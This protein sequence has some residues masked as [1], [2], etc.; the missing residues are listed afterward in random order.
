MLFGAIYYKQSFVNDR[1]Y[2]FY[3]LNLP[4]DES[5]QISTR[6]LKTKS[7]A[8]IFPSPHLDISFNAISAIMKDACSIVSSNS[9]CD[10][11]TA[12]PRVTEFTKT[13]IKDINLKRYRVIVTSYAISGRTFQGTYASRFLWDE[14]MDRC[15][16]YK[17]KMENG[18]LIC[19][20]YLIHME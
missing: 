16:E 7:N 4:G 2:S 9:T 14:Q 18:F 13:A 17:H 8:Y 6:D 12:L 3:L 1:L 20:A 5:D 15:I 19:V 11:K 10:L